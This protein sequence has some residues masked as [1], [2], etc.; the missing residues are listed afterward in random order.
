MHHHERPV[1]LEREELIFGKRDLVGQPVPGG[2]E[3]RTRHG[4]SEPLHQGFVHGC[5]RATVILGC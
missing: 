1:P 4:R 5:G 3:I 2:D